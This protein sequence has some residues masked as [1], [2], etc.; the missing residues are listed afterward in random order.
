M[1]IESICIN[2][3][4]QGIEREI[5]V[6]DRQRFVVVSLRTNL[7]ER[8]LIRISGQREVMFVIVLLYAYRENLI[9]K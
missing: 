2:Y 1:V 4:P 3:M 7:T 8:P 9:L 5:Q 6:L